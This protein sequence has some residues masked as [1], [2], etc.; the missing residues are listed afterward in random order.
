[1]QAHMF[2]YTTH[3]C[4]LRPPWLHCVKFGRGKLH[5]TVFLEATL[6]KEKIRIQHIPEECTAHTQQEGPLNQELTQSGGAVG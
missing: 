5:E 6:V 1:M 3:T 2:T 4:I